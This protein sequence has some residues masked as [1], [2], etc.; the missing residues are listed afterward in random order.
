MNYVFRMKGI[1]NKIHYSE[2]QVY[3]FDFTKE[4]LLRLKQVVH[5]AVNDIVF[6]DVACSSLHFEI[7]E[8]VFATYVLDGF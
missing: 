4:S 5:C 1:V 3:S 2:E 7:I 8:L 6:S